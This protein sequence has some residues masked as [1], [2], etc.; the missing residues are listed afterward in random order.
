MANSYFQF[1]Q[2]T[3]HQD[4]CAMKVT[5]DACLFGAWVTEKVR[6]KRYKVQDVLDIGAGTGLLSLM[7]AQQDPSIMIDAIEIDKGAAEQ[8]VENVATSPF[9]ERINITN[10]DALQFP[11]SRKYD[12]IV[13]NP[14]FYEKELK[15][16]DVR[17][18]IA[19]HNE[20]LLLPDLLRLIKE[21][22]SAEGSFFILLPYKRNDEIRRLLKGTGLAIEELVLV[23]QT[24]KHDYFRILIQGKV[25][26][27]EFSETSIEEII[28]KDAE[29]QYNNSFR[30]LLKD[31][32]LHL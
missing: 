19:H 31:Y 30:R 22:L 2:F 13:S 32:Y 9:A 18:N 27:S 25:S 5:T 8:A 1:K 12:V 10:A 21:N 11:F 24:P 20:G 6:S 16:D 4:K 29:D 23:R 15:G 7:V 3:V 28:I 14:P 17:K 26:T